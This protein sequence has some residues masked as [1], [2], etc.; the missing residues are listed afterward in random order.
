MYQFCEAIISI[1]PEIPKADG[2]K[3]GYHKN[4]RIENNQFEVYDYPV[5]Y[6]KSTDDLTFTG[7]TLKAS[8]RFKPWHP[9]KYSVSLEFCKNVTIRDNVIDPAVHGRNIHL[10]DMKKKDLKMG[11]G[12]FKLE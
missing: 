8:Q 6:A 4:I 9:R 3:P 11:K 7:N 10:S 12:Q 5:L 2:T 1:Y